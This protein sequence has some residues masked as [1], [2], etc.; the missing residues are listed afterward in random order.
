MIKKL[1]WLAVFLAVAFIGLVFV[2]R[3][4]ADRAASLAGIPQEWVQWLVD[5]KS[6]VD[7]TADALAEKA[8]G[9]SFSGI[10]QEAQN[11]HGQAQSAVQNALSGAVKAASDAQA[12]ALE[13]AAQLNAATDAAGKLI[14]D[15]GD[16]KQKVGVITTVPTVY[17]GSTASGTA[18][19]SSK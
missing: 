2:N 13:K 19:G 4:L 11:L 12:A 17:S 9:I 8:K 18:S 3:P 6:K 5:A 1:F 15:A 14:R 7:G 16:L 10:V